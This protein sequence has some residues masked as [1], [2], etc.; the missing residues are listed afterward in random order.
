[1][2]D[3]KKEAKTLIETGVEIIFGFVT[4]AALGLI[5]GWWL[6]GKYLKSTK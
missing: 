3:D 1:M 5:F 4:A 2:L 6:R